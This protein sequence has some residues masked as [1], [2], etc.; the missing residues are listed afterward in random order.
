ML[1]PE[2]AVWT[3]DFVSAVLVLPLA[4]GRGIASPIPALLREPG[5]GEGKSILA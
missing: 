1:E 3:L 5:R 4:F 2:R